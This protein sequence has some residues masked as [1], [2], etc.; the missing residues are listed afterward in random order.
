[1]ALA[2]PAFPVA[3]RSRPACAA[4]SATPRPDGCR[5]RLDRDRSVARGHGAV[6]GGAADRAH[7]STIPAGQPFVPPGKSGFLF[8]T[9]RSVAT[10][11]LVC[12]SDAGELVASLVVIASGVLIGGSIGLVAGAT[13]GWVDGLL[14]RF[15]DVF[16]ALPGPILAIA[17][18]RA[19]AF[20]SA[21]ADR[22]RDRV[23]ALLRA[24]R[25]R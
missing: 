25:A 3:T 22:G 24:H 7:S 9:T 17:V 20:D 21:H 8:G 6:R 18:W 23:V 12:C 14:M 15:T 19:R 2:E 1:M 4:V 16:L 11:S 10:C 13:G 5:W